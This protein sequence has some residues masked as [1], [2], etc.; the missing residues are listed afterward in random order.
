MLFRSLLQKLG[1]EDPARLLEQEV[2]VFVSELADSSVN[3]GLRL[4]VATGDYWTVYFDLTEQI[5]TA[6]DAAGIEMTYDHLNVHIIGDA[7][8]AKD[9]RR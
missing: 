9:E 8:Q 3:L 5:K 7:A 2:T 4:W 1:E 6:F